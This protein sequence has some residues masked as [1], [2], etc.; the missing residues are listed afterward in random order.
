[1]MHYPG[2]E[3]GEVITLSFTLLGRGFI[4]MYGGPGHSLT[5][6]ISL[7]IDCADQAE[8]DRACSRQVMASHGRDGEDQ[9]SRH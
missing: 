9:C 1:M 6:P 3:E 8:V 7:S 5:K 2:G 4:A